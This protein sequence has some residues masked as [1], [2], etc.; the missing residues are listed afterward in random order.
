ML[1][2]LTAILNIPVQ[3][4]TLVADNA[5]SPE[6]SVTFQ[7][8]RRLRRGAKRTK[9]FDDCASISRWSS[10]VPLLPFNHRE[11]EKAPIPLSPEK[12]R[13]RRCR[14][15]SL[16]GFYDDTS[17]AP[18]RIPLRRES[19]PVSPIDT[20]PV[21]DRA[22]SFHLYMP[23]RRASPQRLPRTTIS[24][25]KF[26]NKDIHMPSA[27]ALY[28]RPSALQLRDDAYWEKRSTGKEATNKKLMSTGD[29]LSKALETADR[30]LA[31]N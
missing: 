17:A 1:L 8:S 12:G 10:A 16:D 9:S 13:L 23:V 11:Q 28:R 26:L 2:P 5:K 25:E 24:P 22:S 18:L 19:P 30:A 14:S 29:C 20:K 21:I 15:A 31:D 6:Q 27:T 7:R 4:L 3:H